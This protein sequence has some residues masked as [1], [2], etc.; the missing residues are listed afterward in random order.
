[1]SEKKSDKKRKAYGKTPRPTGV[2]KNSTQPRVALAPTEEDY[3]RSFESE[4]SE[5]GSIFVVVF[6]LGKS[7]YALEMDYVEEVIKTREIS[8]LPRTPGF[9]DG[10]ISVR[11]EMLMLM[12]LK[13]RLGKG[14]KTR[15][16]YDDRIVVVDLDGSKCGLKV[17]AIRGIMELPA[18]LRTPDRGADEEENDFI[19]GALESGELTINLIHVEPLLE[20]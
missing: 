2:S 18:R 20:F 11:G 17:D 10:V 15:T 9:I 12:D 19:K 6:R 14:K 1:M 16:L 8:P 5:G 3:I 7:F 13:E 4:A